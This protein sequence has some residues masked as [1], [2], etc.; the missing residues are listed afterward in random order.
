MTTIKIRHA[1]PQ[2]H[3]SV[4]MFSIEKDPRLSWKAKGLHVYLQ[5]RPDGWVVREADLIA[6]GRNSR[7]SIRSGLAELEQCGYIRREQMKDTSGRYSESQYW[8][9]LHPQKPE[10]DATEDGKS[11][12]GLPDI[13]KPGHLVE[14]HH[15][16]KLPHVR[17]VTKVTSR[18][19]HEN[20]KTQTVPPD[21]QTGQKTPAHKT[22]AS[23]VKE[24]EHIAVKHRPGTKA[25]RQGLSALRQAL[26]GTLF[27]NKDGYT[28]ADRP[29]SEEEIKLAFK[30]FSMLRNNP[31]YL[32][33]P[34]RAR[35]RSVSLGQFFYN[36][37][38]FG[39]DGR[40]KSW[41]LACLEREPR[42]ARNNY[43]EFARFVQGVIR[44]R[45]GRE[46]GYDGCVLAATRAMRHY[47]TRKDWLERLEIRA[48]E[49]LIGHWV[50]YMEERRP[51]RWRM[52][53]LAAPG[54]TAEF[55]EWLRQKLQ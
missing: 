31:D 39:P 19:L 23:L 48:P 12:V 41:F 44:R 14:L 55:E 40:G 22:V 53:H 42:K 4:N 5:T 8:V 16:S 38:A 15:N 50:D 25:H 28:A 7:D 1:Q 37:H 47:R 9:Y 36:P 26:A 18:R 24:W 52:E 10:K 2:E 51:G 46:T 13:G 49:E 54:G 30:R 6:R 17:E 20:V 27:K 45:A 34:I 32:S 35:L 29:Y 21:P 11:G 3:R 43:P 33:E